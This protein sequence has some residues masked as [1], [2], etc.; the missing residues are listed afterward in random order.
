MKI[1]LQLFYCVAIPIIF[2]IISQFTLGILPL[3]N[4]C[5]SLAL[6]SL[7]SWSRYNNKYSPLIYL[8][9]AVIEISLLFCNPLIGITANVLGVVLW[10]IKKPII[11]W[12]KY[13]EG[14][15]EIYLLNAAS[16]RS[17]FVLMQAISSDYSARKTHRISFLPALLKWPLFAKS[18][19]ID[20]L[21]MPYYHWVVTIGVY[22]VATVIYVLDL[23]NPLTPFL[24]IFGVSSTYC[25]IIKIYSIQIRELI[26]KASKGLFIPC[27]LGKIAV[28]GAIVP[29]VILLF[30][31]IGTCLFYGTSWI[32]C[33]IEIIILIS[34]NVLSIFVSAKFLDKTR[35]V[36]GLSSIAVLVTVILCQNPFSGL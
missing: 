28:S 6:C 12:E 7:L 24:F 25:Y 17:D 13:Y 22:V 8:L 20:T 32:V 23:F 30:A 9:F 4:I 35:L 1:G 34:I 36:D 18:L 16:A 11:L 3:L 15:R 2:H 26:N 31:N 14:M 10:I 5:L 27:T 29:A 33:L 21:R 19:S